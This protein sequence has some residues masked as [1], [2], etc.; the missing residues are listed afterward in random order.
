MHVRAVRNCS[1]YAS[2]EVELKTDGRRGNYRTEHSVQYQLQYRFAHLL[3]Y[4]RGL[5]QVDLTFS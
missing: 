1:A 2:T 5:F 4:N 3:V